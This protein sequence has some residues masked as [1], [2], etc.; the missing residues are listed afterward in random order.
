MVSEQSQKGMRQPTTFKAILQAKCPRCHQGSMFTHAAINLRRFDQM[1]EHCPVC[2][3]RYEIE[4]GFYWGAMYISYGLSVFL[5]VI[6]G[7]LL[8]YLG[9]DPPL[10]VYIVAV[11]AI[12]FLSTPILFRYARVLMLYFFGSVHYDPRYDRP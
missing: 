1:P 7:V 2:G 6:F 9:D 3:F 11:S 4:L 5:L 10:W 8:Y 12:L